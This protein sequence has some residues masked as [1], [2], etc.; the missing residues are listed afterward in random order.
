MPY[1]NG[2][3]VTGID[4]PKQNPGDMHKVQRRIRG[5]REKI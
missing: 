5:L 3:N 4:H 2:G 1:G